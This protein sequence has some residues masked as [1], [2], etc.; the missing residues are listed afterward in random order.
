MTTSEVFVISTVPKTNLIHQSKVSKVVSQFRYAPWPWQKAN[1]LGQSKVRRRR[2][3]ERRGDLRRRERKR[4]HSRLS[5]NLLSR[6]FVASLSMDNGHPLIWT[7]GGRSAGEGGELHNSNP[8][9]CD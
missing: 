9:Q 8:G 2:K 6:Y 7:A 4:S 1:S 3:R 5:L